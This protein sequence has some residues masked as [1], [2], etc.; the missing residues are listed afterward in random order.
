MLKRF[1]ADC[2]GQISFADF[3]SFM[4]R[5]PSEAQSR[6]VHASDTPLEAKLRR[7][8]QKAE[9][10]GTPMESAFAHFD[11][12]SVDLTVALRA[13]HSNQIFV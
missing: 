9:D 10:L 3:L 6:S 11:K 12:V 7:V 2:D 8:V 1:D 5:K 13:L 4:G